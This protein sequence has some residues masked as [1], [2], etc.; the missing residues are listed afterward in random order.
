MLGELLQDVR[1]GL[2]RSLSTP[3][4][5][6]AVVVSLALA[7]GANSAIFGAIH[8]LLLR[9][10]PFESPER[11]VRLYGT[12]A[13]RGW[14]DLSLSYPNFVDYR[15]DSQ[16]LE[17]VAAYD[18][19]GYTLTG[20]DRPERVAVLEVTSN[21]LS[22]LGLR[23]ALGR[24][25]VAGEDSPNSGDRVVL[26]TYSMWQSRFGGAPDV[27][28]RTL[29]LNGVAHTVVGVLPRRVTFPTD[30][31]V[32][33]TP[34]RHD[35]STWNRYSGGLAVIGR[36]APGVSL[37]EASAEIETIA[38]R[39]TA[40]YPRANAEFGA[41]LIGL[42]EDRYG[43]DL[44]LTMYALMAA[45]ALLLLIACINV[46]NLLLARAVTRRR[47]IAVRAALGAGRARVV[48]LLLSESL[49]L[50][51]V[52][53]GL[54][55]IAAVGGM[56]LLRGAAPQNVPRIDQIRLDPLITGFTGLV[57]LATGLLFGL[58]PAL[59]AARTDISTSLRE[60]DRGGSAGVRGQRAQR[61]L[62]VAQVALVLVVLTGT[63]LMAR[64][65][66]SLLSV[67]PGFE[68]EG[69]TALT[70]SLTPEYDSWQK[71]ATYRE[72][73]LER[74]R[75]LPGV[76][77]AGAVRDLPLKSENNL[78]DI[79]IEGR[80]TEDSGERLIT[81]ANIA[82]PGYF[83][84]LGIP[85]LQGRT[86]D[87]G[88]RAGAPLVT[89]VSA[90]M[91]DQYWPGED[92]LGKRIALPWNRSSGSPA[93]R[94]IVGVVGDVRHTGLREAGRPEMYLPFAQVTWP[95][96]M[97]FVL[98]ATGDL[99]ATVPAARSAL[100]S[101]DDD[102]AVY[103]ATTLED[104]VVDALGTS[105]SVAW[106]LGIF[107]AVALL[108]AS[109]GVFG[110][111]ANAVAQ[112]RRELGI[113]AALGAASDRL[114]A[115]ILAQGMRPVAVGLVIG[116]A[117]AFYL[118]RLIATLLFAIEPLDPVTFLTAPSVLVAVALLAIWWPARRAARLDPLETLRAE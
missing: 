46:A 104:V 96:R 81:G 30:D 111:V 65:L 85:L 58:V 62:V 73:A 74:L 32:L 110:L 105:R 84:T 91:A 71:A 87:E 100:W 39:L 8:A 97:T 66:L 94:T 69:R 47:E 10:F 61:V 99:G 40:E 50:A 77:S 35:E 41:R 18:V 70:V 51:L 115:M 49:V 98:R 44:R 106:L 89:V 68:S 12:H 38:A 27:V 6:A 92:A 7:I 112:R 33:W 101:V 25:F 37:G 16:T 83:R 64:S 3:L 52:G 43:P 108:L 34:L 1:Y 103:G 63:G 20:I 102:Q 54:G 55:L 26:L 23:P 31:I 82:S 21:L 88:D 75:A 29:R 22:V 2:R 57:A 28:G 17:D 114:F 86:F 113:R 11:L 14:Q 48:A 42:A 116:L 56:E 60:G 95:R 90:A 59:Q 107:G 53:G 72:A 76:I 78:W 5:T 93:W 15:D 79:S 19:K 80:P 9:P 109:V 24:G 4:V 118:S 45:V 36:L 117:A 13:E 67:D